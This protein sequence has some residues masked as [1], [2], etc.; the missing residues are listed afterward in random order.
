ML[1]I[2]LIVYSLIETLFFN[3]MFEYIGWYV[4][5]YLIGAYLR[6]YPFPFSKNVKQCA[7]LALTM[8]LLCMLSIIAFTYIP[9]L[10]KQVFYCVSDSNKILAIASAVSFF[11]FFNS[12]QLKP[13]RVINTLASATFGIFLIHANGPTMR[14]WLWNDT[15][16]NVTYFNSDYLWLHAVVSVVLVYAVCCCLDLIRQYLLE[17]PFFRLLGYKFPLLA[18]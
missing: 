4:T 6:L 3:K 15:L 11:L 9:W 2:L 17:K 12:I 13:S 14:H 8:F 10:P 16:K 5:V 1:V 18:K 7:A